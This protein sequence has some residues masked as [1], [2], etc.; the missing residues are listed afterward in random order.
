MAVK[1]IKKRNGLIVDFNPE[2]ITD[3]IFKAAQA[4]GGKDHELAKKLSEIVVKIV[5]EKFKDTIPG[6][7]DVQ[8]IVE[9]AL[10]D[11]GHART[12]KAYIL[13]RSER[14][15]L[16]Q[17]KAALG[18]ADD[19][20]NL[21]L[22]A[23]IVLKNRYLRKDENG[24]VVETP[25][26]L[27]Q[28]V[29]KDLAQAEML[30]R[31][32]I[33]K[34]EQE[35]FDI[36]ANLDFLPNTPTLMNAGTPI[37]Q[38]S[39]CFVLPVPDDLAGIFETLK[40]AVLIHQTGGGTGFSFSRLRPKGDIVK[41][42]GG[43]ASGPVSFMK[44]YDCASGVIKQGGRRRGANMAILNADH[45]DILEFI[46]CKEKEGEITNFNISC[47]ITEKFMDAVKKNEDYDLINPR[48]NEVF[49]RINARK[50][51][52]FIVAN[53]WKNG[54]PG[55]IFLDRI[56]D[57]NTNPTPFLGQI[58]S[59]NPCGEQPL[60][61]YEACNLGSINL[62]NMAKGEITK[63]E[64]DWEK[65]RK[66]VKL[67][68]R[69]LDNA[70]DRSKFPLQQI[71]D[72]VRANRRIGLGVMGF[73][74]MLIKIGIP[75]NNKDAI[76]IA[77]KIMKFIH[78]EAWLMSAELGLKRGSF[79]NFRRSLLKDK[80]PAV[81]NCTAT[82]IA[83]TGTIGIIAGCSQGIEP[84]F[85][86]S[87]KRAHVLGGTEELF[88]VHHLFVEIAKKRGFYSDDLIKRIA[89]QGS[90]RQIKEIPEDVRRIFITTH[91]CT[92]EDHIR[93]QAA[94]QKYT[95]NAVSKTVNFPYSVTTDD[96]EKVYM[97]AYELGCKGVTIYRDKSREAQVLNIIEATKPEMTEAKSMEEYIYEVKCP[98]CGGNMIRT[99][100][101]V[102]C[103][104]CGYSKCVA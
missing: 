98:D 53:A 12:A 19:F 35:F 11:E 59:T 99:E 1:K 22:N 37:Q 14:A 86:V 77:E 76:E 2:K 72:M 33:K 32:D 21:S 70:A 8:D 15:K 58:E 40:Q 104:S 4:V 79:P 36:T 9:K 61:P 87:F 97:L 82:T 93:I 17:S 47:G 92:P 48:N 69:F 49:R 38:L 6:V 29:A 68:V 60:L 62:S 80:Y 88:E 94:F 54:E 55:I 81:R 24:D 73:A 16:R 28:R 101:C 3:A 31:G 46:S 10:I 39:A 44:A 83:P 67:A 30:Y 57:K 96:V 27:F 85:A 78:D 102:F 42:T 71:T 56:N 26:Q 75:Y 34:T 90:I 74:D 100:G 23:L 5:N 66:T 103:N 25:R 84:I 95:N 45:P 91:D 13:Y 43:I 52:D 18:I 50:V 20:K 89:G 41:T 65:L 7:E 64:I 51:F 63:A